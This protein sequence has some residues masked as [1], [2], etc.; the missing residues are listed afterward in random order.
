MNIQEK[1]LLKN[2]STFQIGG[3]AKYFIEV[4]ELK[5]LKDAIEWS[6]KKKEKFM[7]LGGGSN[8]LFHDNGFDGLVV[9]LK[10]SEIKLI[11]KKRIFCQAGAMLG[12]LVSFAA[13]SHLTGMEWAAGIPGTVGGAIRGNAGAFGTEMKDVTE[14]VIYLNLDTLKKESCNKQECK[15][16]Y[17]Q[18]VFKEFDHKIIWE[19]TFTLDSGSKKESEKQAVEIIKKRQDKQPCLSGSGSAGSM[20]KNPVV[21][22]ELIKLFEKESGVECRGKKVPAGWLID[23][24]GLR[25][26][27][28]GGARVSNKQANFIL[29]AN[30]A[31]ANDVVI[32][33]SLVKQKVRNNFNIQLEEEVQLVGF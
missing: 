31:T 11:D 5:D 26:K 3:P 19:A 14:E 20:F 9:R 4:E 13:K 23:M 21:R 25:G 16:D 12:G 29:N 17:R 33:L 6:R 15:F 10:N 1:V 24:C 22:E 2:Y 32:L 28:V 7:I 27:E 30:N 18:S 8:I